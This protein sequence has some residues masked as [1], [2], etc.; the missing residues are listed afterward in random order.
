[1]D[2]KDVAGHCALY[3]WEDN[4]RIVEMVAGVVNPEFRS[5]GCLIKLTQY[6][7]NVPVDY[8]NIQLESDIAKGILEHIREHDPN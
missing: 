7:N 1:M 3:Y 5:H 4:P 2:G 8:D 6:L